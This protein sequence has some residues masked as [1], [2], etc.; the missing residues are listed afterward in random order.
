M[1][2]N[3]EPVFDASA[4]IFD[5]LYQDKNTV[6]EAGWIAEN[7]GLRPSQKG[8]SILEIG[9]GTGRHA[10]AFA[11]LDFSITAVEPS[12]EMLERATR[13]EKISYLQGDGRHLTLDTTFDAVLALFHVVSYQTSLSDAHDFFDTASRHLTSGG[14]FGFDVWYSPAVLFHRPEDRVLTKEDDV[15]RV[16]REARPSEDV[17]NSRVDVNYSYAVEDLDSGQVSAF[18]E[19]H[20]MRHFTYGEIELLASAH[21]MSILDACEFMT[22]REPSRDTWGVW[23]VLKKD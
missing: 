22:H 5:L 20:A 13:H 19:V 16:T 7:L 10:R 12:G 11:D 4:R 3:S 21:G 9:A 17:V 8:L 14:L 23:F 1:T 6:G 2:T 15:L 18:D